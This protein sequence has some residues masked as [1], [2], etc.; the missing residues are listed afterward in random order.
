MPCLYRSILIYTRHYVEQDETFLYSFI[1][2]RKK[3]KRQKEHDDFLL[4]ANYAF[5]LRC[6]MCPYA[7]GKKGS[8]KIQVNSK[9]A[10]RQLLDGCLQSVLSVSLWKG[11]VQWIGCIGKCLSYICQCSFFLLYDAFK[12]D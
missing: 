11:T 7:T 12:L 10:T 9:K 3:E 8:K 2:E 4:F 5:S 6:V 1:N